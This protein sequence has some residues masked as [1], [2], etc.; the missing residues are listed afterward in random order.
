MF[1]HNLQVFYFDRLGE[2]CAPAGSCLLSLMLC[3]YYS[4]CRTNLLFVLLF[5]CLFFPIIVNVNLLML[6]LRTICRCSILI[7]CASFVLLLVR[8]CFRL[9]CVHIIPSAELICCLFCCF[10]VFFF[11]LLS[12]PIAD[13]VFV[14]NLQVFHFDRLGELLVIL[15]SSLH[16]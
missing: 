11:Q 12:M 8:V 2:F 13:A 14:H 9:C 4:K 16:L 7:V 3:T 1:A 5:L 15:D 10:F 6:C